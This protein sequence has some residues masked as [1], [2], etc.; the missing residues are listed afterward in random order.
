MARK[1]ALSEFG[2]FF[3]IFSFFFVS[4]QAM[5]LL[6]LCAAGRQQNFHAGRKK[7]KSQVEEGLKILLK[8]IERSFFFLADFEISAS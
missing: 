8:N 4:M 2:V 7:S 5:N 3:S 1:H 6:I